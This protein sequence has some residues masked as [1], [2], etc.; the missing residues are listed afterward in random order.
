MVQRV[1]R[2]GLAIL[3]IA[4][5]GYLGQVPA[6]AEERFEISSIKAIRPTLVDTINGPPAARCCKAE[7][8]SRITI[9][10][11][12]VS[13]YTSMPQQGHVPISELEFQP[14]ITKALDK[15]NPDIAEVLT[16][17]QQ[18]LPV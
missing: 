8:R 1:R 18:C 2:T 14:R 11:G 17:V 9:R 7:L 5:F 3:R 13:K 4:I 6:A 12:T 16:D 15:L 10:A